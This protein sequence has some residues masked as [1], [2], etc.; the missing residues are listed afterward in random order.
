MRP[1]WRSSR[2]S[3][4]TCTTA[5]GGGL[6]VNMLLIRNVR[7]LGAAPVDVL[8]KDGRIAAL[9]PALQAAAGCA[10][11]EGGGRCCCPAWSKATRTSTRRCGAW[12]G[13][14]TRS[15]R[16]SSTR[17]TTS[18]PSARRAAMTRP[19]SR[20]CW[21][22]PSWRWARRGCAPTSTSTPEAGLRHLEGVLRTRARCRTCRTSRSSPFRNRACWAGPAR[23]SCWTQAIAPGADVLGGLDPCA[24]DGDPVRSLDTLFAMAERHGCPLD[25]HLHEPG[26]M[27]AFSLEPDPR[28]HAG[29]RHAG[30]GGDQPRLLPGRP[31]R[32]RC[33]ALLARMAALGVVLIT[34]A[35]PSRSVPPLMACR[36]AGVTVL[37]GNDGIRDTWT[38][39]QPRHAGARDADRPALQPAARRR[40]R[41]RARLRHPC[42]RTRLRLRG[43]WPGAG[44]PGRPGAGRCADRR[45]SGG[46]AARAAAGGGGRHRRARRGAL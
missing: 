21:P 27:G 1:R 30:P 14:A 6:G 9:G 35:P 15:G 19:R 38:P 10:V 44:L 2:A 26:A 31:A 17:S 45:R 12:T 24:I 34:S 29:A 8:V 39:W 7:P 32:A 28:A 42:G 5:S 20:L 37:G 43:L 46:G 36:R 40:D 22:G 13:T 18:A 41:C 3:A 25:I 16:G 23:P 11:E 4:A 33:E